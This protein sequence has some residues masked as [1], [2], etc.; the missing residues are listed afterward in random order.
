V[1]GQC[2]DKHV[3]RDAFDSSPPASNSDLQPVDCILPSIR[4]TA[5]TV[6]GVLKPPA[7]TIAD[8]ASSDEIQSPHFA[9]ALQYYPKLMHST[10]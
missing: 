6:H 1:F 7:N 2:Y 10:V 5:G 9:E 4:V 8:L 3:L